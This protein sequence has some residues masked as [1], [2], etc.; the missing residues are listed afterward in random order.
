MAKPYALE[1]ARL[2]QTVVWAMS[3]SL[4][5][6]EKALRSSSGGPVVAVGSGGSLSAAHMLAHFHR[7][8]TGRISVVNT[9]LEL[10]ASTTDREAAYW[11]LSASGNNVDIVSAAKFIIPQEPRQLCALIS[12]PKSKLSSLLV[13]HPYS[14]C[15]VFPSPAGKDGFLA[16]NSLVA[17]S[18]LLARGYDALRHTSPESS[19]EPLRLALEDA[20]DIE[21]A[22]VGH[23]REAAG[24]LWSRPT[25]LVLYGPD[26]AVGAIDLESKFTEAAIGHVQIADY[27]NF[28]HGRHVWLA[29]RASESGVIAFITPDD[30]DLAERTIGLLPSEVPVARIHLPQNDVAA[31][32]IALIAAL[33]LTGWSGEARGIDPGDPGVPNFGRRLYHLAPSARQPRLPRGVS[34]RAAAAIRRKTQ[35][36]VFQLEAIGQLKF[37]LEAFSDFR[38][39]I[40]E[41]TYGA[42]VLDYDGTIVDTRHRFDPPL[43]AM[44]AEIARLAKAGVGVGVAT[45]RGSSVR[46][47]LQK[48]I[49]PELWNRIIVGYYNGAEVASLANSSAP[50]SEPTSTPSLQA[51]DA[52]LRAHPE[53]RLYAEIE[54]RSHQIT[55]TPSG[56]TSPDR[57]WTT[58][59]S[60]VNCA[61][62]SG[63]QVMLSSHSVDIM[64]ASSSK[65]RVIDHFQ[66]LPNRNVLTIGD[67]GTW[68]GNDY[69]LLA[70][71]YGL[72]VDEC[73]P[74]ADACWNLAPE[75]Q[76]GYAV[77]LEYLQKLTTSDGNAKFSS[78][79]F[80]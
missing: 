34:R 62:L 53:I 78:G 59:Q 28:A 24:D 64:D 42:V 30:E 6:L 72:S 18:V 4:S 5:P 43:P 50:T 39:R 21:S 57:L 9:P 14:D 67:K 33:H 22:T 79:A 26:S 68:P 3:T 37:W 10:S 12:S 11:L 25:T 40:V 76:R 17:F 58:V 45:G 8:A 27:R 73:S 65:Q 2:R 32:L 29:K 20:A 1:I 48:V 13:D 47:D 49:P 23:W 7:L 61:Q 35:Q 55:L 66:S 19:S 77:T 80:E 69:L 70:E 31:P 63:V 36:D 60:L 75:G 16:T 71:D 46:R 51:V 54:T 74:L 44:A 52:T 15:L 41:Q 56:T 38:S